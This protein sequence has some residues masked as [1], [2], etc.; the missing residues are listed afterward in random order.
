[1]VGPSRPSSPIIGSSSL[2]TFSSRQ[3]S[4]TRGISLSWEKARALSRTMRS[5]SV[6]SPSRLSGSSQLK[7]ESFSTWAGFDEDFWDAAVDMT[8]S[9][10]RTAFC[11]LIAF[12]GQASFS[13][14]RSIAAAIPPRQG[15]VDASDSERPGGECFAVTH[16][17]PARLALG[18]RL[19]A[20]TL[21]ETGRD[22]SRADLAERDSVRQDDHHPA[23][24][25]YLIRLSR[26]RSV[27]GG[28]LNSRAA[29]PPRILCFPFSDTN[30][31]S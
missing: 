4:R 26:W 23:R 24:L 2:S 12:D 30:G 15:R 5:S 11:C 7:S 28:S 19:R 25:P 13:V 16:G 27:R 17:S 1:M 31:R 20:V 6:R 8:G 3:A 10:V 21:P 18:Y 9:G 14:L 29:L 22:D